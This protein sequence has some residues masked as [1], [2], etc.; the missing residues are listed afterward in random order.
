[1]DDFEE[2]NLD[3]APLKSTKK[4]EINPSEEHY[5]SYSYDESIQDELPI[6][7]PET[8]HI[9]HSTQHKVNPPTM[10]DSDD[11]GFLMICCCIGCLIMCVIIILV[12][13][14]SVLLHH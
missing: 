9:L 4:S 5:D 10:Y 11:G 8:N 14:T 12:I 7:S 6:Y 2:I 3:M 13:Q 1:M